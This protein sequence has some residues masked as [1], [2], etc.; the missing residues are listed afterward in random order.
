LTIA[1]TGDDYELTWS[2]PVRG[3]TVTGYALYRIDLAAAPG[4][5]TLHCEAA[6]PLATSAV[7]ADLPADSGF[8]VVARNA[9]GEGIPG[10]DS[11]G[12]DRPSAEGTEICP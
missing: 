5:L 4:P 12:H 6:L 8:L 2:E 9:V 10:R 3:G 1:K 7:V 11:A